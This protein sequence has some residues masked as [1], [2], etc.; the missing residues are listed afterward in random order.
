MGLFFPVFH[1]A[2][3]KKLSQALLALFALKE[4][5]QKKF[6]VCTTG[7]D[8]AGSKYSMQNTACVYVRDPNLATKANRLEMER[9]QNRMRG[10]S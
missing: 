4:E 7:Q 10:A 9:V 6:P 1:S 5:E 2:Q 8:E 3:L